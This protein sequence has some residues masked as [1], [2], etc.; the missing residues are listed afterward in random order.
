M[1]PNAEQSFITLKR[2]FLKSSI[3]KETV[4]ILLVGANNSY[5]GILKHFYKD[6]YRTLMSTKANKDCFVITPFKRSIPLSDQVN[7]NIL[8][9]NIYLSDFANQNDRSGFIDMTVHPQHFFAKD[10]VHL[11]QKGKFHLGDLMIEKNQPKYY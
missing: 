10:G 3:Q 5:N 1:K 8:N 6:F 9:L 7:W 11:S 2:I 4:L